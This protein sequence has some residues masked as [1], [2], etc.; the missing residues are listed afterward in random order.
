MKWE[1][2][3]W[4]WKIKTGQ[5]SCSIMDLHQLL[6]PDIRQKLLRYTTPSLRIPILIIWAWHRGYALIIVLDCTEQPLLPNSQR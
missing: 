6:L 1:T 4:S 3:G 2:W 5:N